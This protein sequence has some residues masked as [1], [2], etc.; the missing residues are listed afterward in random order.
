MVRPGPDPVNATVEDQHEN[1]A[2]RMW[3]QIQALAHLVAETDPP[4]SV[5]V[6]STPFS[7]VT[8]M[9]RWVRA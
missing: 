2:R 8:T 4:T 3:A 9:Q 7:V 1:F 5:R 6:D